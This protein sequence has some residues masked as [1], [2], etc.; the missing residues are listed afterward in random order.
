MYIH[1]LCFNNTSGSHH[2]SSVSKRQYIYVES[3]T[4]NSFIRGARIIHLWTVHR[5]IMSYLMSYNVPENNN[6]K[7]RGASFRAMR[8]KIT[9]STL[10]WQHK[11]L[12]WR[13][14]FQGDLH[15][16]TNWI[17][18]HGLTPNHRSENSIPPNLDHHLLNFSVLCRSNACCNK[19]Y[20]AL[21][22]SGALK[23]I[24]AS[25]PLY[26]AY[27]FFYRIQHSKRCRAIIMSS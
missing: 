25:A 22:A 3:V 17:R 11:T 5:I 19:W 16:V 14:D 2:Q 10:C 23:S 6:Y 1:V 8:Q 13:I 21:K 7:L 18:R 15:Q 9:R 24:W 27:F 12:S 26:C 20:C 4:R